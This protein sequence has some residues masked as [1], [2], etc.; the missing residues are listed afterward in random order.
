[1]IAHILIITLFR[2][3]NLR[4]PKFNGVPLSQGKLWIL[5]CSQFKKR[6]KSMSGLYDYLKSRDK[7]SYMIDTDRSKY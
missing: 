3:K 1:M 4:T 6:K 7:L 5:K 2:R